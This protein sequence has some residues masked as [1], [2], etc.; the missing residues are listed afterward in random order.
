MQRVSSM[1]CTYMIVTWSSFTYHVGI[2]QNSTEDILKSEKL[3]GC[4]SILIV[5]TESKHPCF[6]GENLV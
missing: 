4:F 6:L 2:I 5:V 3:S 1:L